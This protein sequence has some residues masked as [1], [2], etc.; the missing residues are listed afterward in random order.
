MIKTIT[1]PMF[2]GK[3]EKLIEIYDKNKQRKSMVFKPICDNRFSHSKVVSRNGHWL[4]CN[5]I[6]SL[7]EL[8]NRIKEYNPDIVFV[9]EF[10]F[11]KDKHNLVKLVRLVKEKDIDLIISCLDLTSEMQPFEIVS[12]ILSFSDE[13]FKIKGS[14]AKCGEP[15]WISNCK[16]E[17]E[18]ELLIG[19]EIYEP[20]CGKC[21]INNIK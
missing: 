19:N 5:N 20:L 3:T 13:V 14:C 7:N 8:I 18:N 4:Y 21:Y 10:Q 2:S 12:E 16:I 17:K 15:S 11:L 1:G 6:G 9:D